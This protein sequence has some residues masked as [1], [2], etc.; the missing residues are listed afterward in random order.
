MENLAFL[1]NASNL[2]LYLNNFMHM[3][4]T[5]A[6]TTVTNFMGSAFLFALVGGFF[7]DAFSTTY[8]VYLISAFI[9]F[10][11]QDGKDRY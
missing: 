1:G 5:K 2:V 3:S 8:H 10:L 11:V 4:L 7:S 9:E 6:A